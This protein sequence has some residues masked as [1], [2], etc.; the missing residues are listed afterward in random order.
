MQERQR[1]SEEEERGRGRGKKE[2]AA[3][4]GEENEE[5]EEEE[6]EEGLFKADA[7]NEEDP[8]GGGASIDAKQESNVQSAPCRSSPLNAGLA[9]WLSRAADVSGRMADGK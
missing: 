2:A 5:E 3:A 8:G 7:V 1:A 6:E 4:A 9:P